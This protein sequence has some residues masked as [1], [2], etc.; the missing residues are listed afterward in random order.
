M[1]SVFGCCGRTGVAWSFMPPLPDTVSILLRSSPTAAM[2]ALLLISTSHRGLL[3]WFSRTVCAEPGPKSEPA[4][5]PPRRK[6][7]ASA[8]CGNGHR[9]SRKNG[10][11]PYLS[12]R[13][14]QRDRDD[15]ALLAAL[16]SNPEGSIA[17]WATTIG[18]SRT[19]CVSALHRLRD[20][21]L[22]ESVEGKWKLVAPE[23]PRETAA[24]WIEPLSA[25]AG[26]ERRA[27]ASA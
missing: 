26:R 17:D 10:D 15:E 13:R 5:A 11:D 21:G 3:D 7:R 6:A 22:A 20:A 4:P 24:K 23:A 19:S 25:T 12:G 16:R 18:K 2:A 8:R 14:A 1:K 27:H 9:Q